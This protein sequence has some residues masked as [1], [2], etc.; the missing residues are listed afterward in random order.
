MSVGSFSN[1]DGDGNENVKKAIGLLSKTTSL[2]V[3][4][5]FLYIFLPLL[6]DYD[7]KMLSFTF[8]RG[9]KTSDD[10]LFSDKVTSANLSFFQA[11]CLHVY[12]HLAATEKTLQRAFM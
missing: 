2:H 1:D 5:A 9:R 8:Y 12:S 11:W 6:H 7:V 4:H 3:H 10:K